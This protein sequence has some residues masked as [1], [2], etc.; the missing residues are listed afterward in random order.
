M[1][2]GIAGLF[3]PRPL[4]RFN[5]ALFRA[6]GQVKNER[7]AMAESQVLQWRIG[8]GVLLFFGLFSVFSLTVQ[9]MVTPTE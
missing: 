7:R 5:A 1:V 9:P 4:M 3:A 2:V 8:G 6:A